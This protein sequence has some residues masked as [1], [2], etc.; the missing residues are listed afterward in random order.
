[1]KKTYLFL[2]FCIGI[3]LPNT[4]FA[5]SCPLT[6][7]SNTTSLFFFYQAGSSDC[8]DRPTV[9]TV[10][11][12]EFTLVECEPTYSVY[13]LSNGTPLANPS[14][15]LSDFGY[16]TCEYTNGN[17]TNE[18]LSIDQV[19]AILN[20]LKVYPNPVTGGNLLNVKFSRALSADIHLY[21]VTGKLILTNKIDNLSHQKMD[22][23][24]IPNGMYFL[25]IGVD[26]L[27]ITQKVVV[28]R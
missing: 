18:T 25:K 3:I 8:V 17:L 2:L 9:V 21:D 27:T 14:F 6:G 12:N 15:F 10:G 11:A 22:L 5:Q 23:N 24:Q 1:M 19:E 13:D 20:T 4:A 26:N 28:M 16:A 7:L